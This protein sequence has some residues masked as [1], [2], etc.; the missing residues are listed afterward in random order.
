MLTV[1]DNGN[2]VKSIKEAG[3][4]NRTPLSSLGS[5]RSTDELHMLMDCII[6][7]IWQ[8]SRGNFKFFKKS[9]ISI[10]KTDECVLII[11]YNDFF[12][13]SSYLFF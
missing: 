13:L 4:G 1:N 12:Q 2:A 3:K 10:Q 5:W 8:E 6:P 11:K 9:L 7:Q